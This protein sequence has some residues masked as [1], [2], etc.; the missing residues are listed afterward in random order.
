MSDMNELVVAEV[1]KR[2]SD[3]VYLRDAVLQLTELL[4]KKD[5]V[6]QSREREIESFAPVKDFFDRVTESED[7]MEMSAAVKVL[8]YK[9]YGRN[10]VFELLRDRQIL[11]YNNEPYQTYVERGYFKTIEQVFAN[12]YGESMVNRKTMVSQK[13]LNFI[14]KL[15]EEDMAA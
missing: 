2:L 6:I 9:G 4:Q 1:Q 8:G 11:R 15:I 14:R 7:W 10:N 13:G 12:P 5:A 3:P